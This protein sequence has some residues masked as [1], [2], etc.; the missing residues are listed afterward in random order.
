M[1]PS[2]HTLVNL[3]ITLARET[4]TEMSSLPLSLTLGVQYF[5]NELVYSNVQNGSL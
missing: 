1:F 5:G 2:C 4:L 3:R